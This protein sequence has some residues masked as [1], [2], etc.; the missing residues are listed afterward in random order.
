MI[1]QIDRRILALLQRDGRL[2]Y[3]ELGDAVG[4]SG[5]AVFQRV[6]KLESARVITGYHAAV[7]P[8]QVGRPLLA[9]LRVLPPPGAVPGRLVRQWGAVDDVLECH[10]LS[11]GGF[12]LKLRVPSISVLAGHVDAARRAGCTVSLDVVLE[13]PF[14]RSLIAIG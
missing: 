14:E 11:D 10:Q 5:P 9:F 7:S 13:S 6:K 1:D 8:Q 12:L 2:A 4:L 3:H